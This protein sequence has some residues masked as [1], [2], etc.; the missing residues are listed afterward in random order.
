MQDKG[1]GPGP[2]RTARRSF[3]KLGIG[4]SLLLAVGAGAAW[5]RGWW[6][7]GPGPFAARPF[8][9]NGSA[10]AILS[11][12][13]PVMLGPVLPLEP[14][15]LGGAVSATFA[16][17]ATLA[18]AA[19]DEVRDLFSLLALA[20]AR[21]WLAGIS[22]GWEQASPDQVAAFLQGWRG[23]RLRLLQPAYLALHDLILGAWYADPA[24]WAALGYPG[25]V[26]E[27]A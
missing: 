16:A 2:V 3:L 5:R 22:D 6:A 19:Q 18:P 23:H 17:I 4:G 26:A 7:P 1:E 9:P 20:P 21:R 14:A 24:H 10:R 11:A 25:P 15:A 8:V 12:I 27:L 13:V